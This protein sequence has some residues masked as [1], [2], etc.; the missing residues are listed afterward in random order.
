[1]RYEADHKAKTRELVLG[2]TAK[3]IRA[4]GPH[5]IS[6]ASVMKQAG[7]THGGFYAH[8]RSKAALV[9]AAIEHMFDAARDRWV[10]ATLDRSAEA[11]LDAYVDWY[12]SA[13]HRD[14]DAHGCPIAALAGDMPRLP[15]ASRNAFAAG[16]RRMVGLL[17]AQM[18]R[19]GIEPA[20]ESATALVCELMGALAMARCEPDRKRSDAM[21]VAARRR[22][23]RRFSLAGPRS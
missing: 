4:H 19:L 16:T 17:S 5:Q 11:G 20:D 7:L 8:F 3:E 13:A 23:K 12:L 9:T 10:H 21:L 18:A 15:A 22:V 1:M 6:V 14:S 2:A